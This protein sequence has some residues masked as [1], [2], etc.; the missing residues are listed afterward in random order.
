MGSLGEIR[1][2]WRKHAVAPWTW[3]QAKN[4]A[5]VQGSL[6]REGEAGG[7]YLTSDDKASLI[8]G[9]RAYCKPRKV[10][11]DDERRAAREKICSDL[12]YELG[13]PIPP[14][15]LL[16]RPGAPPSEERFCCASLVVH[17]AQYPWW[18]LEKWHK[19][20]SM[21]T[22]AHAMITSLLPRAASECLAFD[23]WVGQPDHYGT[24]G[25]AHN[26]AWGYQPHQSGN[27]EFLFFDFAFSLGYKRW[28]PQ[29]WAAGGWSIGGIPGRP[30]IP[31]VME[32]YADP[33]VL[34]E[35]VTK[36]EAFPEEVIVEIVGRIPDEYMKPDRRKVIVDGLLGRR[37]IVRTVLAA[38]LPAAKVAALPAPSGGQS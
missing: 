37:A 16:E 36:I 15:V 26:L 30:V 14:V 34:E 5:C 21:A 23:V 27:G 20:P 35:I 19:D 10:G 29:D 4:Q 24:P 18:Q 12:G 31:P 7:V 6:V 1:T 8:K 2:E 22:R 13:I 38:K 25:S 3:R 11:D 9:R 28:W 32:G 17:P 33:K